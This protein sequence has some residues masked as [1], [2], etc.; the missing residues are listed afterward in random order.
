MI[1]LNAEQ[2]KSLQKTELEILVE[3]DRI[4]RKNGIQYS[5]IGG[6][7]LG[8]V[9]HKG[10]I[11][12]DDDADVVML[13][14]EYE[15]FRKVCVKELDSFRFYFQDCNSTQGY[16]WGYGKLRRK[17]TLF[18]RE[19]Q[20]HMPYEQG[21]FVDIFPVDGVP[22][23]KMLCRLQCG[24]CYCLRKIMWSAVGKN[25]EENKAVRLLY[26]ILS[27]IPLK[28]VVSL[29]NIVVRISNRKV[30][31]RIRT[32]TFPTP[33]NKFGFPR[34]WYTNTVD[35]E[36]ENHTL[37]G[38]KEAGEYLRF[39]YGRNYMQLPPEDKRKIHPVSE[40]KLL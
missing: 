39:K 8:A 21:V 36:F 17:N 15:K 25:S 1:Q 18:L 4:C 26:Q 12:W 24:I 31:Q 29:Y 5:I 38:L 27:W 40:I 10:F 16:R 2:L 20:E 3:I 32:L 7:L 13:R 33:K 14:S 37:R 23:N 30:T 11:P 28:H 35:I 9:R 6:T 22:D 19:Y 34:K